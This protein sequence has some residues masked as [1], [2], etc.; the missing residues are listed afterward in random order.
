MRANRLRE[1]FDAG[2]VAVGGWLSADSR[3]L[4]EVASHSGYDAVVVDVQHGVFGVDTAV[5]LLQA[6]SGG[7]AVPMARCPDQNAA[8]IGKLLDAGAYGIICPFVDTAADAEAFVRACR[9]RGGRSYGPSR[10]LLY[11]GPDYFDHADDM[12]LTWVMIESATALANLDEILAVKGVDGIFIGPNDLALSLGERPGFMT[13]PPKATDAVRH[14]VTQTRK[15]GLPAGIFCSDATM[16]T[17]MIGF[18]FQF[19][20]PGN[21]AGIMR[22]AVTALLTQIR[23]V[24]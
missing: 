16:A 20:V 3:Y 18:G 12:V 5:A 8:T 6:V 14:I 9:Y 19:V 1:I 24:R 17:A 10:G 4:A 22:Q 23:D 7:P 13:L 2:E 21:D 11:G 15:A